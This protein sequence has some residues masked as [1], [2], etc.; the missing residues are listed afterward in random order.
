MALG[1][2][3]NIELSASHIPGKEYELADIE[4]RRNEITTEWKL[5]ENIFIEIN[6]HYS[7]LP[8]IDLFASRINYQLKPFDS[9]RSEPEAITIDAFTFHWKIYCEFYSSPPFCIAF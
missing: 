5:D 8:K 3:R 2:K 4:S 1:T 9:F 6:K 7:I